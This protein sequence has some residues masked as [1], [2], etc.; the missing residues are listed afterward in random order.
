MVPSAHHPQ[1]HPEILI[2]GAIL[3]TWPLWLVGGLYVAGPVLGVLLAGLAGFGLY[4]RL[5]SSNGVPFAAPTWPVWLWLAGMGAMLPILWV[6]HAQFSLGAGATIKSSVGWAKGWMLM[7]LFVF[8]GATLP[9]RKELIIRAICR[10]GRHTLWLLPLFLLAPFVGLPQVL[11]VSPIKFIGGAGNEY[12]STVLY[13]LEPGVGTPRWQFF[14]PWSPAAGMVGVIFF[15]AALREQ[16]R[17]WRMAGLLGALAL[18]LFSQSRLAIV[19]LLA[20]VPVTVLFARIHRPGAWLLGAAAVVVLGWFALDLASFAE[21]T[22][23]SFSSARADSSRVRATLAR[24]AIERWENEAFWFGHGV[25][26]RGPHLVEYMPIGSHHTW[27]GLLFVKG[28]AGFLALII[29]IATS[30][31][32]LARNAIGDTGSRTLPFALVL[33][34]V[35]YSFGENLEMLAYLTWPAFLLIGI[36]LRRS[37]A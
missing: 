20:I 19:A 25:V 36:G 37:P 6:G 21:Q 10:L 11:W 22:A 27:Y 16:N 32:V 26:E 12:F 33:V 29:P 35:L 13:T 1:N 23:D 14:A 15:F 34:L 5:P 7:G 8:A 24:I 18:V 9:I 28:L 17:R 2:T 3:L 30:T 4:A 31:L